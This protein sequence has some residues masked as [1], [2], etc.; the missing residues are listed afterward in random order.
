MCYLVLFD[1]LHVILSSIHR[2]ALITQT[3]KKFDV[4]CNTR[5]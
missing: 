2:S 4:V 3:F 5:N 1:M